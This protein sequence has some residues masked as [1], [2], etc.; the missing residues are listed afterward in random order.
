MTK[1]SDGSVVSAMGQH[2]R[3]SLNLIGVAL[4]VA[5]VWMGSAFC[6]ALGLAALTLAALGPGEH[7]T[8][9]ALRVTA[10]FSFLL[11]W[12][13]YAAAAMT[14]LFGRTFEPLKRRGREFGLAFA[15]AHLVHLGLVAWLTYIRDAPSR[16][17]FLFFGVAALWTYLLA[18]FSLPRLQKA[19]GSKGWWFLRVVGLNYI[20]FAFA[21]DFLAYPQFGSFKYLVG[22]LPFAALSVVGPS[23]CLAAFVQRAAWL[24]KISS[25]QIG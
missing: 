5:A 20:A 8:T 4:P 22:Y 6:A 18:L 9:A 15:S 14:A 17:V 11:F 25:R 10:R 23:L 3:H 16:G 13:A 2:E 1:S 7:G 12:L 19:L 21:K 24:Q